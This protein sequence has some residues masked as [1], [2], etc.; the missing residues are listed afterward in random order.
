METPNWF[1]AVISICALALVASQFNVGMG[2]ITGAETGIDG[3][4]TDFVY[5]KDIGGCPDTGTVDVQFKVQRSIPTVGTGVYPQ[6]DGS[7]ALYESGQ[8]TPSDT[9]AMVAAT[10]YQST[11][12]DPNCGTEGLFAVYTNASYYSK[13]VLLPQIPYA[14]QVKVA[15]IDADLIA[16]G[17]IKGYNTTAT[18]NVHTTSMADA[19][20]STYNGAKLEL[21]ANTQYGVINQPILCAQFYVEEG[22]A[23]TSL[24]ANVTGYHLTGG[25]G[26][27]IGTGD[28]GT[29]VSGYHYCD[30]IDVNGDG[31]WDENDKIKDEGSTFVYPSVALA[32]GTV[33]PTMNVT[34]T[35]ADIGTYTTA[36]NGVLFEACANP[37]T[38]ADV[39]MTNVDFNINFNQ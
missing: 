8:V 14:A 30:M 34:F 22:S 2:A 7:I 37:A 39:G 9:V 27:P 31:A 12:T 10:S 19:F 3:E 36:K 24:L 33:Q 26:K 4:P 11:A 20:T 35:L 15:P 23:R 29:D 13:K 21:K 28:C 38:L 16:T 17:Q 1:L 25:V 32:S 18:G 5:T 6:I